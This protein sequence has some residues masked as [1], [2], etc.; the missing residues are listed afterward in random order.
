MA[1]VDEEKPPGKTG[2]STFLPKQPKRTSMGAAAWSK[3][4]TQNRTLVNGNID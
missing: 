4:G 2:P 3:I 1:L